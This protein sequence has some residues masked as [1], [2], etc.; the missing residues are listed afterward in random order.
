MAKRR[1]KPDLPVRTA[2][3]LS[4]TERAAI[5][6]R[7]QKLRG[8]VKSF[9]AEIARQARGRV[10]DDVYGVVR[11]TF[12]DFT[13]ILKCENHTLKRSLTDSRLSPALA[14]PTPKRPT[15]TPDS[16]S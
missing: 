6:R 13:Q 8:R 4:R 2:T 3:A 11:A 10:D 15:T 14:T 16:S 1:Q 7:L 5:I 12:D 9:V